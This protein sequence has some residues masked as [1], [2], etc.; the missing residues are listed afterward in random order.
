MTIKN[1]VV[2]PEIWKE[3]TLLKI[4]LKHASL[5]DT[6]KYLLYEVKNESNFNGKENP[7]TN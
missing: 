1:I 2:Q 5:N 4:E 6:I 3:L 7:S